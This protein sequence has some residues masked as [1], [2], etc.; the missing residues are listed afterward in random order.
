MLTSLSVAPS[1]AAVP[2]L[3]TSSLMRRHLGELQFS[4]SKPNVI[5][6]PNG[7]GKSA[8]LSTLALRFLASQTGESCLD[9]RYMRDR[10]NDVLW[11]KASGWSNDWTFMAGLSVD[12]DNAPARYYRPGHIPGN[13]TSVTHA[14]MCGYMDA[15]RTYDNLT[16]NKSSGQ[17]SLAVLDSVTPLL[18]GQAMPKEYALHNW[19]GG[20]QPRELSRSQHHMPWDYQ[21]EVL[22]ELFGGVD[23]GVPLVLLDE[24]EQSLDAM[25]EMRLWQAV[26]GVD[27]SKMQVLVATHS[28]YPLLHPEKF[29]IIEAVDG[30]AEDV[31][32]LASG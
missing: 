18:A 24:P 3:Y 27:C 22:K 4:S 19:S 29:H 16:R 30:Y 25:A 6:G 7:A 28:L 5:V 13:E 10:D 12:T 14:M 31:R 21:A 11:S 23:G 15:A 1:F 9:G 26:A 32:A 2:Y 8:L 20:R 17:K